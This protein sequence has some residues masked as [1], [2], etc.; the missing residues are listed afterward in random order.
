MMSEDKGG[1]KTR[2]TPLEKGVLITR[3]VADTHERLARSGSFKRAFLTT[4]TWLPRD[5]SGDSEVSLQG[6][7]MRYQ[8]VITQ[9]GIEEHR[10][11]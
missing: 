4:G 2:M 8:D 7:N 3:V 11:V 10:K 6:V 9:A 5:H 1:S